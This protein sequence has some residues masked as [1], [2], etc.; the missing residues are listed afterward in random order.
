[1]VIQHALDLGRVNVLS[2]CNHYVLQAVGDEQKTLLIEKTDVAG[3][4]PT[5]RIDRRRGRFGIVPISFHDIWPAGDNL[6]IQPRL[7]DGASI[8]V[9]EPHFAENRCE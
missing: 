7:Y 5:L 2:A 4:K 8:R 1:M 3:V 6:P 9:A